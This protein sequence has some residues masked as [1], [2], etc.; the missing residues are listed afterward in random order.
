MLI[1]S[2]F[3]N[4]NNI[5]VLGMDE[6]YLELLTKGPFESVK[7]QREAYLASVLLP[8][9]KKGNQLLVTVL[10]GCVIT[11]T[12]I[13]ILLAEAEGNLS[14][15]FISTV[16][17]MLFGEIIPQALCNRF[18]LLIGA[19][20]RF[21]LYFFYYTLYIATYPIAAVIDRVLG[22]DEGNFLSKSRM[23][24]LFEQY[25]KEKMLN[26]S[27]R[28]ILS[29]ALELKTKTIGNVMTPLDKAFMLEIN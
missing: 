1:L 9:R 16:L 8:L 27:E 22:D 2:A 5:G 25:E 21:I 10:L 28:K 15:F 29:A 18:G 7:E 19:Y 12:S 13:S 4:G 6:A 11:N 3:C 23:K 26:P 17:T 20:S 14:G 24:K